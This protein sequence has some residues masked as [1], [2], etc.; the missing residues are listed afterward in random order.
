LPNAVKRALFILLAA[1]GIG[2][3]ATHRPAQESPVVP[4]LSAP[5]LPN[6]LTKPLLEYY[7]DASKRAHEQGRVVVKLHLDPSGAIDLP[8]QID[9]E[10]T[11][12]APRLQEAAQKILSGAKFEAGDGYKK[13]LTVSIVFELLPCGTVAHEPTADHRINLCFDPSPYATVNFAEHPPSEFEEQIHKILVHG[14]LADIDFLEATLGL[15]FRVTPPVPS[16]YSF[17]K[18]HDLHVLVTPVLVP[19][20]IRVTGLSYGR[21][22]DINGYSSALNF[23]LVPVECPDIAFWA[24]RWKIPFASSADPHGYGTGTNF[25]WG[26]PDGVRISAFNHQ[27]G[28]CQMSLSQNKE[29]AEPFSSHTDDDLIDAIPLVRGIGAMIASGDIR[30]VARAERELHARFTAA[31]PG[32]F[33]VYYQLQDFISG[34]NPMSFEYSVNDT[35]LEP[36]PF[37]AFQSVPPIPANRTARLRLTVD[38]YH[39]CIRREQLPTELHRRG[40]RFS[41]LLKDGYDTYLIQGRNEIQMQPSLFG[42]CVRDI[43]ISQITDVKH[44]LR[45]STPKN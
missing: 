5:P 16:P 6:Q 38:V 15:R 8:M 39:L 25:Q 44:V 18:D 9:R 2:G 43:S 32:A 29:P 22:S 20:T 45:S 13:N 37:D 27:G 26:G 19:K 21:L 30:D 35:G 3:C 33:G 31:G 7:P 17:G 42:G 23:E 28:G 11:D 4:S 36:S 10:S 40:I 12:A 24:A 14:N 1:F 41:R 34:I